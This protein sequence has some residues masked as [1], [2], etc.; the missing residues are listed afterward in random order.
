MI[1]GLKTSQSTCLS[2]SLYPFSRNQRIHIFHNM[3]GDFSHTG[4][5]IPRAGPQHA[6]CHPS[7]LQSC[8]HSHSLSLTLPQATLVVAIVAQNVRSWRFC[9]M[10][11]VC[12]VKCACHHH[13]RA[14]VPQKRVWQQK[15]DLQNPHS[16]TSVVRKTISLITL[17]FIKDN[18][19]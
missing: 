12:L 9:L 4:S 16:M 14:H 18:F 6:Q 8:N 5:F 2:F 15:I 19:P 11:K 1:L 10:M 13:P 3:K 17:A 7:P